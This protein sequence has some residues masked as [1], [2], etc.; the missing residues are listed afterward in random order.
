MAH[1][2][3]VRALVCTPD[4]KTLCAA[5]EDKLITCWDLATDAKTATFAG[6]EGHVLSLAL[7]PDGK[8]LISAGQ[9]T[10]LLVWQL[11]QR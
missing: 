1:G 3:W 2:A 7:T 8:R 6:H 11:P 4:G 5:G 10:T 9:D